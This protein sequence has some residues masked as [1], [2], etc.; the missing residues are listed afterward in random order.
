MNCTAPQMHRFEISAAIKYR[1]LESGVRA[2]SRSLEMMP[3]DRSY[4]TSYSRSAVT[5]ALSCT[6]LNI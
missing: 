5:M 1:D 3:F 4:T 6:V 2:H